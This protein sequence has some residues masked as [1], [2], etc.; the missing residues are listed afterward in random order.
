MTP[1]K[2]YPYH[3]NTCDTP[4]RNGY[5]LEDYANAINVVCAKYNI[6]VLDM[7]NLGNFELEMYDT[8][9]D[10]IHPSQEFFEKYT[11]PQIAKFI[12]E[13]YE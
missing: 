2:E 12:K 1:Y 4:N 10:G 8:N 7:Y 9:S 6:P 13:N 5:T 11:A 3:S